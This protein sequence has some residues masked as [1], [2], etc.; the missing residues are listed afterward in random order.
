MSDCVA[1]MRLNCA[2]RACIHR[3]AAS[4][5]SSRSVRW[6]MAAPSPR[7]RRCGRARRRG[8]PDI[9]QSASPWCN[10]VQAPTSATR[11]QQ[12]RAI[13]RARACSLS[14]RQVPAA[15]FRRYAARAPRPFQVWRRV[16]LACALLHPALRLRPF[17]LVD[18]VS[19]S[20]RDDDDVRRVPRVPL[21]EGRPGLRLQEFGV[22]SLLFPVST[23]VEYSD[24]DRV[25]QT[26]C[27]PMTTNYPLNRATY[28]Y[29]VNIHRATQPANAGRFYAQAV[30]IVRVESGQ[31]VSVNAGLQHEYGATPDEAFSKIE[32]AVEAWAQR[33]TR[34]H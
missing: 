12:H 21:A 34:S 26:A 7:S 31:T 20:G 15:F 18:D 2:A 27:S 8:M 16:S 17:T 19:A 11:Q 13:Q 10:D 5:R 23:R 3:M 1:T 24:A 32:R 4:V 14:P 30:N 29:D 6:S 28:I 33:Q 22:V 25:L 9:L